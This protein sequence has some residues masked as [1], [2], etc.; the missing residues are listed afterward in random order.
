MNNINDLKN[1]SDIRDQE[2]LEIRQRLLEANRMND[3]LSSQYQNRI[4]DLTHKVLNENNKINTDN[5]IELL[6]ESLVDISQSISK[7]V[8]NITTLLISM[9]DDFSKSENKLSILLNERHDNIIEIFNKTKNSMNSNITNNS[10]NS[11]SFEK[12][13]YI[14]F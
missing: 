2:I 13:E 11:K 14:K 3:D 9:K 7:K 10:N 8:N 4:N 5:F 12:L 1:S 6:K